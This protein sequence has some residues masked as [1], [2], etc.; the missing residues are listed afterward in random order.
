M[1]KLSCILLVDDDNNLL[2]SDLSVAHQV[3]VAENGQQAVRIL[4]EQGNT[5]NCPAL[6]LLDIN[7]P[8]MNGFEFLEAYQALN[9]VNKQTV[10]IMMLT[11][12]LN[13]RDVI[14]LQEMP[15]QGFLSKPLTREKVQQLLKEHFPQK[16][17]VQ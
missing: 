1:E 9:L 16:L 14:R 7:M 5:S 10:V 12:S 6:I 11:T 8:V 13:P 2:L 15:L 17:A 3:L 4:Q